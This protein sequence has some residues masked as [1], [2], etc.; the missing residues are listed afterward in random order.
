MS[1]PR[2]QI[3]KKNKNHAHLSRRPKSHLFSKKRQMRRRNLLNRQL[4]MRLKR[5]L[6]QRKLTLI[7]SQLNTSTKNSCIKR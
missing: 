5:E 7:L 3:K 6:L 2:P 1:T 4:R